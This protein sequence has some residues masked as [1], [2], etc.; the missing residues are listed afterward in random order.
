MYR[1]SFVV[2]LK[3]ES[4]MCYNSTRQ[5]SVEEHNILRHLEKYLIDCYHVLLFTRLFD[6]YTV[7]SG[8]HD[9]LYLTDIAKQ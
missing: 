2:C 1:M 8:V 5:Q 6:G 4:R 7:N 3:T 9:L